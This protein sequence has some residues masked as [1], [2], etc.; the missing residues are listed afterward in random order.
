[1]K[2]RTNELNNKFR[3]SKVFKSGDMVLVRNVE[4]GKLSPNYEGPYSV[5][6]VKKNNNSVELLINNKKVFHNI[7]N[8]LLW[9]GESDVSIK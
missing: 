6:S 2:E 7:K 8:L 4:K 1:M 5:I 3:K 9:K